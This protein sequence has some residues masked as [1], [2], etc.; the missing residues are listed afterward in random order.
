LKPKLSRFISRRLLF[1]KA[2]GVFLYPGLTLYYE[3][4]IL[5]T[6]LNTL[7]AR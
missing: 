3:K 7:I 4:L 6:V 2:G 5:L 1:A